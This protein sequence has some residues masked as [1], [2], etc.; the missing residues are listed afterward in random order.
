[1]IKQEESNKVVDANELQ[2]LYSDR[3][4][5]FNTQIAEGHARLQALRDE[6]ERIKEKLI[7]IEGAKI[8]VQEFVKST[9][10]IEKEE[11]EPGL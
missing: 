1:M 11:M 10:E 2:K 3:L 7:M 4:Q 5:A 8:V 9:H 6:L